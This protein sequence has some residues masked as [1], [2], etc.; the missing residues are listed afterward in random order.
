MQLDETTNIENDAQLM[1]F[2]QYHAADDY[3][4]QFL[5]CCQLSKNTL[6]E[7]IFKTVD[8][9]FQEHQLL[10][11]DCVSACADGAPSM[12]QIR[13]GFMSF[14]KK[15]NNDILIVHF[16]LHRENLAA[17]ESQE[18]L[19]FVFKEVVSVVNYINALVYFKCF[20]MKWELNTVDFCI[21]QTFV[22][23]PKKKC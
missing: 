18:N 11:A 9:F 22:G 3:V 14:V 20:V 4:E 2:V 1:V 5:F 8:W 17:K 23:Y 13:K 21:I 7:E 16:Y 6:G 15:E 12:M 10:W 19:A